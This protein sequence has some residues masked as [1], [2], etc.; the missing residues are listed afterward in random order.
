[1]LV[2]HKCPNCGANVQVED[3]AVGVTCVYCGAVSTA[4]SPVA[5]PLPA[6]T[7]HRDPRP[8]APAPRA[9]PASEEQTD[10]GN[11]R[12][13]LVASALPLG[14]PLVGGLFALVDAVRTAGVGAHFWESIG[15]SGGDAPL[16]ADVDGDGDKDVIGIIH[17][18]SDGETVYALGAFDPEE[19]ARLWK[20]EDIGLE[21]ASARLALFGTR[22]WLADNAGK[23]RT[24][25]PATG[26]LLNERSLGERGEAFCSDGA[27][28]L[29]VLLADRSLVRVDVQAATRTVVGKV[30]HSYVCRGGFP[31]NQA[32]GSA[33]TRW[34]RQGRL[35]LDIEAAT[36]RHGLEWDGHGVLLAAERAEGTRVPSVIALREASPTRRS[37]TPR[38]GD[39]LRPG[40]DPTEMSR[41]LVWRAEIPSG[42]PLQAKE[43]APRILGAG[44]G[45]VFAPWELRE[46]DDPSRL[47]A[48]DGATGARL[49]DAVLPGSY[50]TVNAVVADE[51]R[52]YVTAGT[53]LLVLDAAT[54]EI[55]ST[56]GRRYE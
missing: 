43:G 23:L 49:W 28:G 19:N 52:V 6:P 39:P 13:G 26:A 48:F 34:R 45:R 4:R 1:M 40:R 9:S 12:W 35:D 2:P 10:P 18:T 33:E 47:S 50:A 38:P 21:A 42:D 8:R 27:D 20:L 5:A 55:Q 25:D 22:L 14:I 29:L 41:E 44:G 54:G 51:A 31:V 53:N 46:G 24:F 3:D 15:W 7:P 30:D 56:I 37:S 32:G 11:W 16:V 36:F 17:D